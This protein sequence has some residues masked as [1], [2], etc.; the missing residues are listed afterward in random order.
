MGFMVNWTVYSFDLWA[1]ERG[2]L[3]T[4]EGGRLGWRDRAPWATGVP[5]WTGAGPG[6]AGCWRPGHQSS[7][8]R[9]PTTRRHRP[10]A[11][12]VVT[13]LHHRQVLTVRGLPEVQFGNNR[14]ATGGAA[15][16]SG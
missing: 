9:H 6:R 3:L 2:V 11:A 14:P 13:Q 1:E 10:P 12:L 16:V 15:A 4:M 8:H 7:K 5:D